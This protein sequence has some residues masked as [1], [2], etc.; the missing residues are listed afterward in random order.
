M[1][2]RKGSIGKKI[3]FGILLIGLCMPLI[4]QL[5]QFAYVRELNGAIEEVEAPVLTKEAW[6]SGKYQDTSSK[7]INDNF[8]FRNDFIRIN[9]QRIFMLYNEARANGVII[10]KDNYLYEYGY[11][12]AV[13]GNDYVGR[14]TVKKDVDKLKFISDTLKTLG[15]KI[16]FVFAPGKGSYYPEFIPDKYT[17]QQKSETNLNA[18]TKELKRQGLN[19]VD[20][21]SWFVNG[22][23]T[24]TY[25][26]YGKCGVHWSK[27]GEFIVMDSLINYVEHEMQVNLPE[28]VLEDIIMSDE[29]KEGDYDIGDGMNLYT[30]LS[31]F[32]MAYPQYHF[33]KEKPY[34][35]INSIVV[36]DS[37]YWGLFKRNFSSKCFR[38]GEFWY[39]NK[40][41]YSVNI[42]DG[43]KTEQVD[44]LKKVNDNDL[45]I[46]LST[47]A[48]LDDFG[49]GFIDRLYDSFNA[50]K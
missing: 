34:D 17:Q 7:Y 18:Y 48:N 15:K 40:E 23:D 11:I 41:I 49:F 1:T 9:N 50:T 44:I 3:L 6:F 36:G 33:E 24:T 30:K 21:N 12:A 8:G 26:L 31:T 19:Y 5:T 13:L 35:T 2:K 43:I 4:Q 37:Y 28:L 32:P 20:F 27:Y 16:V 46:I 39:Y 29:N 38:E 22:K 45:I 42:P 10:G 47:D 25:P 14:D